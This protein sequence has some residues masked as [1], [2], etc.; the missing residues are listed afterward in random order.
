MEPE[1]SEFGRGKR[2]VPGRSIPGVHKKRANGLIRS[3][4]DC[5]V[6]KE[7]LARKFRQS[8]SATATTGNLC[9]INRS[10]YMY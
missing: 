4:S 5:R 9:H 3:L 7:I 6:E 10:V 1:E 2:V 8:A